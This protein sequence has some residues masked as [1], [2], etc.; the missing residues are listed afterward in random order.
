MFTTN[1]ILL[2]PVIGVAAGLVAALVVVRSQELRLSMVGFGVKGSKL[3][4]PLHIKEA[5]MVALGIPLAMI[6]LGSSVLM[7]KEYLTPPPVIVER[8][9]I[10]I[11]PTQ[12]PLPPPIDPDG[13][14]EPT[15]PVAPATPT[16]G[17]IPRPVEDSR[18]VTDDAG[19]QDDWARQANAGTI[20]PGNLNRDS[21][22]IV[23]SDIPPQD[24]TVM[25]R[26]PELVTRIDPV[27]PAIDLTLGREGKVYVQLLLNTDGTVARAEVKKSS[28]SA[29]L[30]EAAVTAVRQWVFTPA[31]APGGKAVRVWQL[32]PVSFR[33]SR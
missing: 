9:I 29:T 7:L 26:Y 16:G 18:A 24:F 1:I 5:G 20:D 28:G 32:C 22:E 11:D 25:E 12:M 33:I 8:T 4:V 15:G 30:D 31:I 21:V 6:I 13:I 17:G 19:T 3:L 2:L 23:R 27:Y 14:V 10:P